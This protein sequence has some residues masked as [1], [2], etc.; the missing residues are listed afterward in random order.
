[1]PPP[2][3]A[4]PYAC[5]PTGRCAL[6]LA[7]HFTSRDTLSLPLFITSNSDWAG[8][9]L[10]RERGGYI[11]TILTESTIPVDSHRNRDSSLVQGWWPQ[12]VEKCGKRDIERGARDSL[13]RSSTKT[14]PVAHSVLNKVLL[15]VVCSLV[16]NLPYLLTSSYHTIY[17]TTHIR[18][19]TPPQ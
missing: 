14:G 11:V 6:R 15:L 13:V 5:R 2:H 4:S 18:T 17:H 16:H 19:K 1:L 3:C 10:R 8:V 9:R 7:H 12:A